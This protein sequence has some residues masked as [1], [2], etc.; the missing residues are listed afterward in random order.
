MSERLGKTDGI[1]YLPVVLI[2]PTGVDGMLVVFLQYGTLQGIIYPCWNY[3]LLGMAE[4][5]GAVD[6]SALLPLRRTFFGGMN[7][8][9]AEPG[10]S[11]KSP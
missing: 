3:F 8:C 4:S 2:V 7:P 6:P 11:W 9:W 10:N 1:D 5:S